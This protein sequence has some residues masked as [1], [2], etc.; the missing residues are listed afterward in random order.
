MQIALIE[1]DLVLVTQRK[2]RNPLRRILPPP[3]A[4]YAADPGRRYPGAAGLENPGHPGCL[5]GLHATDEIKERAGPQGSALFALPM[6][7]SNWAFLNF[8]G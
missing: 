5:L 8:I 6:C 7:N 4:G 2:D 3:H 1:N